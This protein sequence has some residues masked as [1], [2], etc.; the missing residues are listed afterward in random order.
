MSLS[1]KPHHILCSI[2]FVGDGENDVFTA[3]MANIVN[4][5]LRAPEGE[6][7]RILIAR[8]A[9]AFCAPCPLREGLGCQRQ[10]EVDRLDAAHAEAL[11][12]TPGQVLSWGECLDKVRANVQPDDLDTICAG[13]VWLPTGACKANLAQLLA[14]SGS[15]VGARDKERVGERVGFGTVSDKTIPPGR[16]RY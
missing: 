6:D 10:D 4:G 16:Y 8:R 9:D 14:R 1:L 2:G 12:V 13:C 5:Q 3:N 7:V 15:H 11:G